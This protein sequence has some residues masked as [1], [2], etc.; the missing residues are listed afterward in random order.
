MYF[1]TSKASKL[2]TS[3]ANLQLDAADVEEKKDAK[4]EEKKEKKSKDVTAL[5]EGGQV[6]TRSVT[7]GTD[8]AAEPAKA[9][10]KK[11][12]GV[13]L[14]AVGREG[15]TA[16]TDEATNERLVY[17]VGGGAVHVIARQDAEGESA[18]AEAAAGHPQA[19][20]ASSTHTSRQGTAHTRVHTA[21]GSMKHVHDAALVSN[22]RDHPPQASG[23]SGGGGG[24]ALGGG[25]GGAS[26]E[27]GGSAG[28]AVLIA[29]QGTMTAGQV[30]NS[31]VITHINC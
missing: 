17:N 6:A 21:A 20:G 19:Q 9:L 30:R 28:A 25:G 18:D 1:S 10:A 24:H 3:L 26:G 13:T 4:A 12:G 27:S 2:S 7:P 29:G 15:Q 22:E 23:E 5:V 14:K 16:A 31:I 8:T 11:R